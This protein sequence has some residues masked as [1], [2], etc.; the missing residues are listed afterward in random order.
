MYVCMY[1]DGTICLI[2]QLNRHVYKTHKQ[3]P[4]NKERLANYS[5]KEIANAYIP[6]VMPKPR[7]TKI[8]TNKI[9]KGREG[10]ESGSGTGTGVPSSTWREETHGRAS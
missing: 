1:V 6:S 10:S 2:V 5:N 3:I 7:C 4:C 8:N 9:R